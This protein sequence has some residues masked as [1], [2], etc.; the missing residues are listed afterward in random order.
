M[1]VAFID[2]RSPPMSRMSLLACF[3]GRQSVRPVCVK[4]QKHTLCM[5]H[6]WRTPEH[7]KNQLLKG[8]GGTTR[9]D[10]GSISC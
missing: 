4:G 8:S 9:E 5:S 6:V 1:T 7:R 2:P 10:H 3:A